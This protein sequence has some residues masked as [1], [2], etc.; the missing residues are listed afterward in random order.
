MNFI[1]IRICWKE[2]ARLLNIKWLRSPGENTVNLR[3]LLRIFIYQKWP[4]HWESQTEGIGVVSHYHTI[5]WGKLRQKHETKE[6]VFF[7]ALK[8][9][10]WEVAVQNCQE[11]N[12]LAGPARPL[13]P[14]PSYESAGL[15][16]GLRP[17]LV[18]GHPAQKIAAEGLWVG[19]KYPVTAKVLP[20]THTLPFLP[21]S[22]AILRIRQSPLDLTAPTTQ[23]WEHWVSAQPPPFPTPS[24]SS[25]PVSCLPHPQRC[26]EEV[27]ENT[28]STLLSA[29]EKAKVQGFGPLSSR[30]LAG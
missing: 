18:T 4:L 13:L 19:Q 2:R 24:C 14:Q 16:S 20:L 8:I 25:T 28:L 11:K 21:P 29:L 27:M 22:S 10:V 7:L 12:W 26:P 15:E 30:P 17:G 6:A 9:G 1:S 23:L 5:L 3:F